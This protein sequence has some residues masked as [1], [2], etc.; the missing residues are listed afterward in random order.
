MDSMRLAV[1]DVVIDA[2]VDVIVVVFK[3]LGA[4]KM[5]SVIIKLSIELIKR[6]KL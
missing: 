1:V 5:L 2:V 6:N 3:F 4:Y